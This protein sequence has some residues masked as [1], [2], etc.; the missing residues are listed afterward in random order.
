MLKSQSQL[1]ISRTYVFLVFLCSEP[2]QPSIA[3]PKGA[4]TSDGHR[5]VTAGVGSKIDA[6]EGA[7]VKITCAVTGVPKPD[8]QWSMDGETISPGGRVTLDVNGSLVINGALLQDSGDYTCTGSSRGGQ[9][10]ATST[11]NVGG[12]NSFL[13]FAHKI[14]G[15]AL[16]RT[17]DV[18]KKNFASSSW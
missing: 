1:L 13:V 12:R 18:D 17:N 3:P 5:R 14:I 11:L 4:I 2:S 9:T 7:T 8:V 10:S 6:F 16:T 15:L